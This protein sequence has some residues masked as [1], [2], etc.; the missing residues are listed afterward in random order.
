MIINVRVIPRARTPKIVANGDTLRVYTNV[1]PTDGKAN[2]AV[3]EMLAKH[4]GV[5][6]SRVSIVRGAISHD[7]VIEIA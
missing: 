6:K 3:I 1:A 2:A 4:Y 5:P 7:K